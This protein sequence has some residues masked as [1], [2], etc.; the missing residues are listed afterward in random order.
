MSKTVLYPQDFVFQVYRPK[1]L[2]VIL[3][4]NERYALQVQQVKPAPSAVFILLVH[5]NTAKI[6]NN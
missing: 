4:L 3:Y 5:V 1:Q 6:T 2:R